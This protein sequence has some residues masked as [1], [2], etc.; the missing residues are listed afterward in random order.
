MKV[1]G[2]ENITIEKVYVGGDHQCALS[3]QSKVYCWGDN[4]YGNWVS[5]IT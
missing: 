2:F 3:N 5:E 1:R 4:N